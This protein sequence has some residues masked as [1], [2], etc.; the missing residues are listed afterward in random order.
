MVTSSHRSGRLKFSNV[1]I[2]T[3]TRELCR[4]LRV[5]AVMPSLQ[6]DEV[7]LSQA[8]GALSAHKAVPAHLAP[9][10]ACKLCATELIPHLLR[11][12]NRF[13]AAPALWHEAWWALL[14]KVTK[15][16]LPKHLRPIGLSEVS[17]RVV[18]KVLQNRLRPYY[19][20]EYLRDLPPMG[21]HAWPRHS[22]CGTTCPGPL[23]R[24]RGGLSTGQLDGQGSSGWITAP[25]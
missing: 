20:E 4:I 15:P 10:A 8:L 1:T 18:G 5:K 22:R 17:S 16:T 2:V 6:L 19:V 7:E 9:V 21:V 23:S 12:A 13:T 14:P 25:S 24:C 3:S 11:I